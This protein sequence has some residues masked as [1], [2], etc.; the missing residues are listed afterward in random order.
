MSS[1]VINIGGAS[2]F[3]GDSNMPVPQLLASEKLD[4]LVFDYLAEI[5]MSILARARV[6]NPETGYA[7]DFV[8]V[9]MK[10]ALPEIA[11]QGIKVISNAGGVNPVACGKAL[12]A[13]I[14]ELGLDLKVATITGDDIL[15]EVEALRAA[16]T[17]EMFTGEEMPEQFLS[18]NAYLGG[19]PV[20][21]A[22]AKGADIV[23][24]GR[25]VDSAVTLGACIHEFGW[26]AE[27]YDQLAGGCL[28]GHIIEC[29]AQASGGLFTDWDTT[30]RWE[31]IGYPIA[32]VSEDGSFTV[33]KPDGT[34]GLV[35]PM[36]VAEQLIYEIGDPQAYIL[37]DVVCDFSEVEIEDVEKDV[38]RVSGVRGT[39]P[40]DTLKVSATWKEGF[41][42]GMY[43][44]IRGIDAS[45]KAQK[46]ADA[47]IKRVGTMLEEMKVPALTETSVEIIGAEAGYGPH[48]RINAPREVILKLAAKHPSPEAL[49]LLL[50]EL[51]SSATSMSPGTGG[52]GG[53]RAKPS[54]VVRLFSMLV[55][56]S[57]HPAQVHFGDESWEVPFVDGEAF[58]PMTIARPVIEPV[59]QSDEETVEIPLIKIAHGRSGD[60]GND[61]N[62]GILAREPEYYSIIRRELTAERVQ[63]YFDY[64]MDGDVTRYDLPGIYGVNFLMRESLGGG[65]IASLRNDPQAKAYA[66]I[67]LDIPIMVPKSL[68]DTL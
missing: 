36:T 6:K 53:N 12:E 18:V 50:R 44:S 46:T 43:L 19:F 39:K 61:S 45:R 41:R 28:A 63:E 13:V 4:Y 7:L 9:V 59:E 29:G 20:A 2:G 38:A 16:D 17:I 65:G 52:M 66:Q 8:S 32:G 24:T 42:V 31:D 35:S 34:G 15:D 67:L 5:T 47:V 54:P 22:L 40:T 64:L 27:D 30:G 56:K 68:A 37:P 49:G 23:I 62:I 48:A 60:K 58:S 26:T 1:K 25:C 14:A 11:R 51:T 55:K 3:W 21:E 10:N 33:F 57:D